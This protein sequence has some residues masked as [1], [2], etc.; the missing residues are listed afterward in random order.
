MKYIKFFV[1][2]LLIIVSFSCYIAKPYNPNATVVSPTY[3]DVIGF[4]DGGLISQ[5]PCGPPCFQGIEL[6]M[7]VKDAISIIQTAAGMNSVCVINPTNIS[8]GPIGSFIHF[9]STN[10]KVRYIYYDVKNVTA[11]DVI[12]K[13]GAPDWFTVELVVDESGHSTEYYFMKLYYDDLKMI[14]E[15]ETQSHS[16]YYKLTPETKVMV[17]NYEEVWWQDSYFHNDWHGYGNY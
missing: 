2:V 6:G 5:K 8:C 16:L 11:D 14:I 7:S 1:Y 10:T 15:L 3:A 12:G 9:D 13:Y 4:N 17:V